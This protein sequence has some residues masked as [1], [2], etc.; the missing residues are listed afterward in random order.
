LRGA[1][2]LRQGNEAAARTLFETAERDTTDP[3]LKTLCH[4]IIAQLG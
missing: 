2:S 4:Q 3:V 1:I